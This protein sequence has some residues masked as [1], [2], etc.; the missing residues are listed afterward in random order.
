MN[1]RSEGDE[2]PLWVGGHGVEDPED[3]AAHH[4]EGPER[5]CP[6]DTRTCPQDTRTCPQDTRVTCP[7][8]S[9]C[10]VVRSRAF[11]NDPG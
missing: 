7:S 10:I 8:H 11:M 6:Q 5:T 1:A 4:V 3:M 9:E 2:T